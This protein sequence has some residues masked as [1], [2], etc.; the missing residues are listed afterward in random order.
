MVLNV[1]LKKNVLV[2]LPKLFVQQLLEMMENAFGKLLLLQIIIHLNVDYS[3]VLIFKMESPLMFVNLPYHLVFL[4]EQFVSLKL[5]VQLIL[6]KQ[7]AMLV[8]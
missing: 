8:D 2:M 6:Q 4:M 7:L 5:N 3:L 1:Y